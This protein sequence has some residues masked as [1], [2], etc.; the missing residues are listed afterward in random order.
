MLDDEI[1][2]IALLPAAVH[3][4][5]LA[6]STTARWLRRHPYAPDE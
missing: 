3:P 2:I 1:V 4:C 5:A 6:S